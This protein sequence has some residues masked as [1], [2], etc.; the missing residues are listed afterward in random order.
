MARNRPFTFVAAIIFL[1]MALVHLYRLAVGF[2]VT[3]GGTPVSMAVSWV[4][5]LVTALL[6]VML[7]R[8][9]GR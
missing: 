1:C 3:I 9:A 6:S 7:F 5:L 2:D 8:E 4:A